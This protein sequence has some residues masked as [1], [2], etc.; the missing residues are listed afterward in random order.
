MRREFSHH[1]WYKNIETS[2]CSSRKTV[3]PVEKPSLRLQKEA[4]AKKRRDGVDKRMECAV[5]WIGRRN[6]HHDGFQ[7][8]NICPTRRRVSGGASPPGSFLSACATGSG[9]LICL[10]SRARMLFDGRTTIH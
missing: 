8:A 6:T 9:S 5:Q 3:Q 2:F 10:R 1:S 4:T 7:R